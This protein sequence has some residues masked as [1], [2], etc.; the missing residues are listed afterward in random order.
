M[1]IERLTEN[2]VKVTLTGD[3][4]SGFNINLQKLTNNSTELHS[5]LFQIMETIREETG[6]NPYSGQIVIESRSVG[7]GLSI[8]ISKIEQNTF[9][10][11]E[12]VKNGKRIRARVR[13]GGSDIS[14]YY[15]ENFDDL[16]SALINIDE[17]VHKSCSL[18][19]LG[20]SY[21]YILDAGRPVFKDSR[22]LCS[23][24]STLSE[25]SDRCS[26]MPMQHLHV[27]EHG[28]IIAEG[29]GLSGMAKSIAKLEGK[30]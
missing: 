9:K 23:S 20:G 3:D 24:V 13:S 22:L 15:F 25:F 29:R 30:E 2:K 11:V 27:K 28:R 7:D 8:T 6:F 4:L 26:V 16:C 12:K 19:K 14:T 21:C 10:T 18:Y 5:F 17:E 1:R